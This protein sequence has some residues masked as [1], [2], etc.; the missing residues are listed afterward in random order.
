MKL[1][2]ILLFIVVTFIFS[3]LSA[4]LYIPYAQTLQQAVKNAE[5]I[6]DVHGHGNSHEQERGG[7]LNKIISEAEEHEHNDEHDHP[8]DHPVNQYFAAIW[9]LEGTNLELQKQSVKVFVFF[10]VL[11]IYRIINPGKILRKKGPLKNV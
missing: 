1:F 11:V 2:K 7:R 5:S 4:D 10:V 9:R 3:V 6:E 8:E